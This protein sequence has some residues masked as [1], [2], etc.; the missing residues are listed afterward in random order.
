MA[1]DELKLSGWALILG[2]SYGFGEATSL[3]LARRGMDIFGVHLDRR[4][5]LPNV[6]RIVG[7]I[8]AMGRKA[9]FFNVNAAD[10]E[11]R[12]MVCDD[13]ASRGAKVR[14]LMH[15]LAFGTL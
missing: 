9:E 15:S 12:R 6:E 1:Q 4:A 13:I 2:A 5:T 7:E 8:R 10:E 3:E 11:K 14:V